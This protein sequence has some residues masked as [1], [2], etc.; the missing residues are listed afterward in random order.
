[1]PDRAGIEATQRILDLV[2][3]NASERTLV[4]CCISGGGA[5]ALLVAP[6]EG[7][8]LKDL[9]QTTE[10]MLGCG[11]K[12]QEIN[13]IRCRLSCVKGGKLAA[14][15]QPSTVATLI[16][17]DVIGD[18]IHLI[19]S[20]PTVPSNESSSVADCLDTI[21]RYDIE[22]ELPYT[23]MKHLRELAQKEAV[24][25][26][27]KEG[28][29]TFKPE[30]VSVVGSNSVAAEAAAV[31]ARSLGYATKILSTTMEGEAREVAGRRW[32]NHCHRVLCG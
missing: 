6:E 1:M 21:S 8:S 28:P 27:S 18:P 15:A 23:V 25:K 29:S 26:A 3:E 16:L 13:E 20:G 30:S 17:S 4:I 11:A 7:L 24:M 19:G 10:S 12:I 22:K 32:R 5:S 31:K 2:R 14:A 9:E